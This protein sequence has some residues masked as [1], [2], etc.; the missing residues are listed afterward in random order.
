MNEAQILV[1]KLVHTTKDFW[2][3]SRYKVQLI[4]LVETTMEQNQEDLQ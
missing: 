3:L 1:R 2:Q 4:A